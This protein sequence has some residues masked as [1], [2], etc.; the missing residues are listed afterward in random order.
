MRPLKHKGLGKSILFGLHCE[1]FPMRLNIFSRILIGCLAIFIPA[2]AFGVYTFSQ[3]AAFRGVTSGIVQVDN[4]MIGLGQKIADS[5]LDQTRYERKYF[6]TRDEDLLDQFRVTEEDVNRQIKEAV[7]IADDARKRELLT[8]ISRNY[9]LYKSAVTE[10]AGLIKSKKPYAQGKY[11]ETKGRLLD[12]IL[13]DLRD[14]KVHTE[15]VTYEKI[16]KLG[17]AGADT[18]R[19]AIIMAAVFMG[20]GIIT[21]ILITRSVTHPLSIMRRKT[22]QVAKGEFDCSLDVPS[23]PE[24]RE[25]ARDFNTMC[26]K[27]KETDKIK[28]DFFSLMAHELR[29]PLASIKEGINLLL[30]GIGEEQREK[31]REVLAIVYEECNNLITLVNSLLDLSRMEAGVIDLHLEEGDIRPLI[32]KVV[33]GMQ[34]LAIAR[35][36]KVDMDVPQDL[37]RVK[38]DG[39]KITQALGN[40]IGNAVK[41]T[42][43]GGRIRISAQPEE[44]GLRVSV[45]DTGPGIPREEL[46]A[47]FD[48]FQQVAITR[49]NK[50]KGTG[51][52]LAIVKHI[53][54]AHGGKVWAESENGKGSVFIFVLPA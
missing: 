31:R 9:E 17:E 51:L 6:I 30:D 29:M 4:R 36:L 26:A 50:I 47:I 35:K 44:K 53:I 49:H 48:K 24:I 5:F 21:S 19:I 2:A 41:F 15:Q 34:P 33:S 54:S 12:L 22:R 23:P 37:P 40:L 42:P 11:E 10:E 32:D 20:L 13:T 18:Y 45:A 8:R 14:L 27:L 3:L 1:L 16:N 7:S 46:Q 38:M 25:L 28:S 52:G 39:Q 43:E